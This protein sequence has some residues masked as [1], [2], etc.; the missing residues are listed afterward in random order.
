LL[1]R[2]AFAAPLYLSILGYAVKPAW[3]DWSSLSLPD[4]LRWTATA[5][6][7][8]VI[9]LLVW[10]LRSLGRNISET[11]L[12][13]G[14]HS[15]V[16]SGP[17][18]WVRHPLYSAAALAFFALGALAANGFI[19]AMAGI[20]IAA[21]AG[22]VIPREEANLMRKFGDEYRAYRSRTGMFVPILLARRPAKAS[23][24]R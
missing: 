11:Y 24:Q 2:L 17:Y 21:V 4:W 12:T 18:R 15:L 13:K 20:V 16:T 19:M 3:M 7:A 8:A 23:Q 9:P 1:L 22:F 5:V 10:I 6:G 14:S